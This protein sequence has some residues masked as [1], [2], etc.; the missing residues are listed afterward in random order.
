MNRTE[1]LAWGLIALVVTLVVGLTLAF[2]PNN[3]VQAPISEDA[4]TFDIDIQG[5]SFVP[6]TIN[7][8]P[9]THVV[10]NITNSDTQQHDLKLGDGHTGRIDPGETITHDFG[11]FDEDTQGWCTI[12][13]HKA[14]GMTFDVV[15]SGVDAAS[16]SNE[17]NTERSE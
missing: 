9:G 5:M 2:I 17:P 1:S 6:D 10:L 8:A 14:M 16:R 12:A 7:V 3:T 4:T 15:T 13:G 11:V